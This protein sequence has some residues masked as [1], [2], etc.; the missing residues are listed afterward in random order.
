VDDKG[1][2]CTGVSPFPGAQLLGSDPT[3]NVGGTALM[4]SILLPS[5]NRARETANRVKCASNMRQIGMA[6]LL[7]ANDNKGKYPPDMGTMLKTQDI[8]A[9]VFLCPSSGNQ[10]PNDLRG[11]NV[12]VLAAWVNANA[13]YVYVG[14][15]LKN[16]APA[17]T[18]VLYEK[19][20]DHDE[21]G[22]NILYGDGHVE[23]QPMAR[24]EQEIAKAA[25][26]PG[27]KPK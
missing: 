7:Y 1:W 19:K 13:S 5:L 20:E 22:M 21:D 25:A 8:V 2:H 11:A 9:D 15:G 27:A 14:A 3:L 10:I 18:V 16:D 17:E 24:A 26:N 23:W 6:C 4:T 12:D